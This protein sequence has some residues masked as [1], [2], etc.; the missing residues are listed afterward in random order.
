MAQQRSDREKHVPKGR[1]WLFTW[2]NPPEEL[3]SERLLNLMRMN[4]AECGAGQ[5]ERGEKEGTEHYQFF[6]RYRNARHFR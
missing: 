2:N 1:N 6:I 3:T 5:K 4:G